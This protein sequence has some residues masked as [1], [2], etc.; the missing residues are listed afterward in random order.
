[1]SINPQFTYDKGNPLG[2]FLS[3]KD[4][5]SISKHLVFE[6]PQSQKDE[7]D[8]RLAAHYADPSSAIDADQFFDELMVNPA[9]A[10]ARYP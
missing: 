9:L 7:L 4:W 3:M 1:M 2:V 6:M 5:K 8:K 10:D